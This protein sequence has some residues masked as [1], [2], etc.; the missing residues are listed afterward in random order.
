MIFLNETPPR[1]FSE[2][3]GTDISQNTSVRL[4]VGINV[5]LVSQIAIV[6]VELCEGNCQNLLGEIL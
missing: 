4:P 1:M 2:I 5:C 6:M 3:F